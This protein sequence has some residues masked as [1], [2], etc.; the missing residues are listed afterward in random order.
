MLISMSMDAGVM[1][2]SQWDENCGQ[3]VRQEDW[4]PVM[5]GLQESAAEMAGP[6]IQRHAMPASM[7]EMDV[8]AFLMKMVAIQH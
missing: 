5:A 4:S 3:V 7:V 1:A 6:M 8:D 2:K